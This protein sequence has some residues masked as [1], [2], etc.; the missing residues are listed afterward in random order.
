MRASASAAIGAGVEAWISKN[1][2]RTCGQKHGRPFMFAVGLVDIGNAGRL[3]TSPGPVVAGVGP[4][5]A[6]LGFASARIE[7]RRPRLVG[8]EFDRG[9]QDLEQ[10]FVLD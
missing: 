2:R 4:E 10:E 1:F 9:L 7:H 6:S 5:L 8:E 3:R